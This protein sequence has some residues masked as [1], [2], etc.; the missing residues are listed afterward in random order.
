MSARRFRGLSQLRDVQVAT[1]PVPLG[2]SPFRLAAAL[3]EY[4]RLIEV[5][6][7]RSASRRALSGDGLRAFRQP[8]GP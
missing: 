5:G 7:M 3:S 4:R 8:S 2:S 6:V 1:L